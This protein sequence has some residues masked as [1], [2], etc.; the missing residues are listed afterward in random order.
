MN[1]LDE[2]MSL[3]LDFLKKYVDNENDF[4][5][6]DLTDNRNLTYEDLVDE[7]KHYHLLLDLKT[8]RPYVFQAG[9]DDDE[10]DEKMGDLTDIDRIQ[11]ILIAGG[12]SSNEKVLSILLKM[13]K[14]M[15]I[16]H[17]EYK[18]S[19]LYFF[20]TYY[21]N[22]NAAKKL[23]Q[24][25]ADIEFEEVM[26]DNR[27]LM[28]RFINKNDFS[29]SVYDYSDDVFVEER[30]LIEQTLKRNRFCDEDAEFIYKA[31]LYGYG[32]LVDAEQKTCL[33]SS[34]VK[35][36]IEKLKAIMKGNYDPLLDNFNLP[37]LP[38]DYVL[39]KQESDLN[40]NSNNIKFR[41]MDLDQVIEHAIRCNDLEAA[42]DLA[43]N[44]DIPYARALSFAMSKDI[45][46]PMC[47]VTKKDVIKYPNLISVLH[48]ECRS[49]DFDELKDN[50]Q[51]LDFRYRDFILN[52]TS[53]EL[54]GVIEL[55][56]TTDDLLDKVCYKWLIIL[57]EKCGYEK[58]A[59][60]GVRYKNKSVL[61][62]KLKEGLGSRS[63]ESETEDTYYISD[64]EDMDDSVKDEE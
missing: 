32:D 55:L 54:E 63:E 50:E 11:Q 28:E 34:G 2:N 23:Y 1:S 9:I 62:E 43:K 45:V 59:E 39:A 7:C 27:I 42:G 51:L 13:F 47:K 58:L 60:W 44:A 31:I 57:A 41:P 52:L 61:Y 12:L 16:D 21:P 25:S 49:F 4:I 37:Y 53:D 40:S 29:F 64:D 33:F 18:K 48:M 56:F 26:R 22:S 15:N 5:D 8:Q 10:F 14:D 3:E 20:N 35:N 19:A 17:P 30:K 24:H 6:I 38:Y 46:L 36:N